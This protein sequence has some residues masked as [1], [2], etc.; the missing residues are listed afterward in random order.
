MSGD[1]QVVLLMMVWWLWPGGHCPRGPLS[2][3]HQPGLTLLCQHHQPQMTKSSSPALQITVDTKHHHLVSPPAHTL[4]PVSKTRAWQNNLA[5]GAW[6]LNDWGPAGPGDNLRVV[7]NLSSMSTRLA[8]LPSSPRCNDNTQQVSSRA[9][10]ET[11]HPGYCWFL[12][13]TIFKSGLL[14]LYQPLQMCCP[15][16][17]FTVDASWHHL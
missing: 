6:H 4:S 1:K 8:S 12:Q 13:P 14:P 17:V 10:A 5:V 2:W 9:Q 7:D 11:K 15:S 16:L 3:C